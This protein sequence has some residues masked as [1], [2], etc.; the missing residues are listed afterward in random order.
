[1]KKINTTEFDKKFDHGEVD[2]IEHLDFSTARRPNLEAKRV[3]IDFPAW[4]VEKLDRE[5]KKLGITRQALVKVWIAE[6]IKEA[7]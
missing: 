5:S 2:I 4:V 3:N 7:V 6:K 1:M